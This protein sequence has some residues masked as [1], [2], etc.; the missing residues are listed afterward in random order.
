LIES[1]FVCKKI[2]I[3]LRRGNMALDGPITKKLKVSHG[4]VLARIDI[5]QPVVDLAEYQGVVYYSVGQTRFCWDSNNNNNHKRNISNQTTTV[6]SYRAW[7]S[8]RRHRQEPDGFCCLAFGNVKTADWALHL[9]RDLDFCERQQLGLQMRALTHQESSSGRKVCDVLAFQVHD[10]LLLF[11]DSDLNMNKV[12]TVTGYQRL[13]TLD[14]EFEFSVA[15]LAVCCFGHPED[16]GRLVL[17]LASKS[18]GFTSVF[19][20]VGRSVVLVAKVQFSPVQLVRV[21]KKVALRT[22]MAEVW[23]I[24]EDGECRQVRNDCDYDYIRNIGGGDHLVISTCEAGKRKISVLE[25]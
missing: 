6:M 3:F 8:G 23:L 21:G 10:S 7:N 12:D 14:F 13:Y 17:W 15:P 20:A 11:L 5:A 19:R 16:D 25:Y 24:S 22:S 18:D 2:F 9:P 4:H 1:F